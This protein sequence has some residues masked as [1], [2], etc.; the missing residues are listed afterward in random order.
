MFFMSRSLQPRPAIN[1]TP[2]LL[3]PVKTMLSFIIK[4]SAIKNRYD[5]SM[6]F[7]IYTVS[8]K[9]IPF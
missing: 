9:Y 2:Q 6:D 4:T 1:Y 5:D 3:D 7:G 8:H